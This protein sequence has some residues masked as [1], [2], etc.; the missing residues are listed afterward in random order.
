MRPRHVAVLGGG[1]AGLS[2]SL[3]LARD[4]HRVT[5]LERDPVL[6]ST[7]E[8]ALGWGREGIPHYLQPHHFIPRGRS[9]LKAHWGDVYD[10]LIH[11]G[12]SDVDLRRKLP[13]PVL[14]ADAELQ[15]V[16]A[17]RPL[18]EWALRQAALQQPAIA[19]RAQVGVRGPR[20]EGRRITGV[21]ID[22]GT[23]DAD[24]VVDA[25]GRGSPM[26]RWLSER[27]IEAPGQ[28]RSPC[29]VIYYSRYF[30]LRSGRQ[31]PEGPW[32]LGPRGDLGYMAY[33]TFLGDNNTFCALLAV[34]TGVPELRVFR[35]EKAHRAAL[36]RIAPLAPWSDP[37]LADPITPVLPMGG[38]MNSIQVPGGEPV[39]GLFTAGDALCHT[40]PVLAHGLAFSLIH[41]GE[42]S[43][44]LRARE[45]LREAGEGYLD[46]VLPALRERYDLATALDEQR[47]RMWTGG[48][49]DFAHRAG[50]YAL[51][52]MLA[53]AA[54]A[55]VDPAV[56]RVYLRR[57]GLLDSTRVLD[58]DR[59]MQE[60]IEAGFRE[61]S[62]KR[63]ASADPSREEMLALAGAAVTG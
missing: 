52:S 8:E 10:S 62:A 43:R 42:I 16:A 25:L 46:A 24:L 12:A 1:I 11:A 13:G 38:L 44:A 21:E 48:T 20:L 27:G 7:P 34:P 57:I 54:V 5:L 4:G 22:G 53:G 61:L 26:R 39:I 40:D 28:E 19:V 59:E 32:L 35:H 37:G 50:D 51:F 56:F 47:Y 15:H 60:R 3:L 23:L 31:F 29:G 55:A 6:A 58:E 36:A 17:R 14:P 41:A 30:R 9:E 18:I 63:P 49:V 2:T 45:D 33:G